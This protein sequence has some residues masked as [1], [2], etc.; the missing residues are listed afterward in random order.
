MFNWS[1]TQGSELKLLGKPDTYQLGNTGPGFRFNIFGF[2]NTLKSKTAY[3]KVK[4]EVISRKWSIIES[5]ALFVQVSHI[6]TPIIF[7]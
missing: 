6:V 3:E 7:Y 2:I 4:N 1:P 5:G